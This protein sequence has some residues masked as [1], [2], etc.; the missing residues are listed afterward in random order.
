MKILSCLVLSA[1]ALLG[2]ARADGTC[3]TMIVEA[4]KKA[5]PSATFTSCASNK[6][7]FEVRLQSKAK[8]KIEVE[9]SPKGEIEEIE[10]EVAV[11]TLPEPVTKAFAAKYSKLAIVRVE[12]Q[13]KADKTVTFEL[14][15]HVNGK[16]R[17]A[18]FKPDGT[19]VEEE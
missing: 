5:F 11:S 10:E 8:T 9:L 13:T 6:S 3:P 1:S 14:A 2:T 18:T 15:F 19:F 16:L 7:H 4:A 12:K 17:E